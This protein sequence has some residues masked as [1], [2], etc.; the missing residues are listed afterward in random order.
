VKQAPFPSSELMLIVP[1][2]ASTSCRQPTDEE[3]QSQ[4][5]LSQTVHTGDLVEAR[6]EVRYC[7]CG[8]P[9]AVIL[10]LDFGRFS[11]PSSYVVDTSQSHVDVLTRGRVC[12]SVADQVPCDLL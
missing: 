12:E 3:S 9:R 6:E 5:S 4:S 8:V 7:S 11:S 10:H 1:P 2:C